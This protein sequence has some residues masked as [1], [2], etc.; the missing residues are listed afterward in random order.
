M[1]RL[2]AI[3][4][5]FVALAV[6]CHAWSLRA[7]WSPLNGDALYFVPAARSLVEGNGLRNPLWQ[8]T[9]PAEPQDASRLN[10]HGPIAPSM[11]A[12]FSKDAS[13]MEV[14]K[15][16]VKVA[17][18]GLFLMAA[19]IVSQVLRSRES[20]WL[21]VLLALFAVLGSGWL[22]MP[23]GRPESVAALLVSGMMLWMPRSISWQWV[24]WAALG[25]GTLVATAPAAGMLLA[26]VAMLYLALRGPDDRVLPFTIV[27]GALSMLVCVTWVETLG[28]GVMEWLEAMKLHGQVVLWQNQGGSLMTYWLWHLESPLLALSLVALLASFWPG[29]SWRFHL[30]GGA[31]KFVAL[32]A[33]GLL[34][35]GV[36]VALLK[37]ATNYYNIIPLMACLIFLA[38]R[39]LFQAM[40]KPALALL[41]LALVPSTLALGR[42]L[43]VLD[44]ASHH[45]VSVVAA[46]EMLTQDLS[47]LAGSGTIVLG[48]SLFE[49]GDTPLLKSGRVR[50]GSDLK[51]GDAC[52]V[53]PQA[54]TGQVAPPELAGLRLLVD[55]FGREAATIFGLPLA[56]TPGAFG[57]AIYVRGK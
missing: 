41:L 6:W 11:W 18:L 44:H 12:L 30:P 35:A 51:D 27:L 49:L 55:R 17:A 4:A 33:L 54:F 19:G 57:Y 3:V 23:N 8:P 50:I 47:D 24:L 5:A 15:A 26:P 42:M 25:L 40:S 43:L 9:L 2:W 7:M 37:I 34:V 56:R 38:A 39:R 21:Q 32:A 31:R 29:S 1:M 45:G 10:W 36:Y 46:R 48:Q 28:Y 53:M 14:K 52:L 20:S 22:F 13:Y 16:G